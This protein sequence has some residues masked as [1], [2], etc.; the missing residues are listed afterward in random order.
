MWFSSSFSKMYLFYSLNQII[1]L[2]TC[3]LSRFGEFKALQKNIVNEDGFM[4]MLI[5][6]MK[7]F[8]ISI[9][10]KLTSWSWYYFR[11]MYQTYIIRICFIKNILIKKGTMI[12][13]EKANIMIGL[14]VVYQKKWMSNILWFYFYIMK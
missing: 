4:K 9:E 3:S 11:S 7:E 5:I 14:W 6:K 13:N 10:N 2:Q 12:R 1:P 8:L